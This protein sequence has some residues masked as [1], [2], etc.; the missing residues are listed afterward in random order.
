MSSRVGALVA[1]FVT[2]AVV[3]AQI[4]IPG[5]AVFHTWQYALALA[6]LAYL[7]VSYV[8]PA[9]RGSDGPVGKMVAVA[10]LGMLIVVADGLASGLLGPDTE[11]ISRAP[12]T[13]APLPEL[14]AAAFFVG[15]DPTTI[16]S[17]RATVT[18]RRRAAPEIVI[19]SGTRRF[20]GA[21]LLQVKPMPAAYIDATD[22]S[23]NHQTITQQTSGAF[24]SPVLLFHEQ[25]EIMGQQ[26]PVDAFQL[27][28]VDRNVKAIYFNVRELAQ[29]HV[30]AEATREPALLYDVF[31]ASSNKS[32]GITLAPSGQAVKIAGI[33][34]RATVGTYPELVI[35]SAP[36]PFVLSFGLALFAFGLAAATWRAKRMLVPPTEGTPSGGD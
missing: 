2:C 20:F 24:L 8:A 25:Q 21:L 5:Q 30:P 7:L 33:V 1:A 10:L 31:K 9:M 18:L 19:P 26:H 3:V 34:V 27:P 4:A 16:A 35:S 22:S 13:I 15:A 12:G 14:G 17:G 11:S 28:A 23:G 36:E 29:L 32:I 6:V